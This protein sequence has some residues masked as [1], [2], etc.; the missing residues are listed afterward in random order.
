MMDGLGHVGRLLP[1]EE[2]TNIDPGSQRS[3]LQDLRD[4]SEVSANHYGMEVST[5]RSE[6]VRTPASHKHLY[7]SV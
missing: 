1:R 7:T 6:S 3:E 2:E 5:D 4:L